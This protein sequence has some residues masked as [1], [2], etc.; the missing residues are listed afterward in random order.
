MTT[1][2]ALLIGGRSG[3][4]KSTV[5]WE[6]SELLQEAGVSHCLLEGDYMGQVH[7]A[8]ADDPHR[9]A[10]TESNLTA[11]WA[12]FAALGHRRLVYT[13]T[14]SVL[15]T[16]MF[17]RALGGDAPRIL[18][19]LLTAD[20]ATTRDRLAL[21]ETGTQLAAH[22]ERSALAARRLEREVPPDTTRVATDGRSVV[23]VAREV[24]AVTGW[25]VVSS[26]P[27]VR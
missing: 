23:E 16:G 2:E 17:R 21:R 1:Y 9:S 11:V 26:R 5:A 22:I 4:G 6:V 25:Q 14:V 10:I 13:N 24:V 27:D 7:P 15:E 19:V 3:V 12:N 8:P 20:D 18:R